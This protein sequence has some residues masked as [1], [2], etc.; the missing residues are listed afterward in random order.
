[1]DGV[2]ELGEG[3]PVMLSLIDGRW[4]IEASNEGGCAGTE[5]DL[6]DL[7][8]WLKSNRPDILAEVGLRL[9]SP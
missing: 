4:T 8:G 9:H 5:V 1:M 3:H 2:R 6:F 7:L